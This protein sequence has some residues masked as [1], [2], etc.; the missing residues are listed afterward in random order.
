MPSGRNQP[1]FATAAQSKIRMFGYLARARAAFQACSLA[2]DQGPPGTRVRVLTHMTGW[3]WATD[4][5]S[6]IRVISPTAEP[7]A[8]LA[9]SLVPSANTQH[10][11]Y[12]AS[13]Q[14]L[15]T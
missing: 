10:P 2:T 14:A 9:V 6:L 13:R 8:T 11:L 12:P 3:P 15:A 4:I 1:A 7:L 5:S